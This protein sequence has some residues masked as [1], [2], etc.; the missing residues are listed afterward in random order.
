MTTPH[1]AA[2]LSQP[3]AETSSRVISDL[4]ELAAL[5]STP[6]GAQRVAWAPVWRT[7][8]EWLRAKLAPLNLQLSTDP[9]GNLWATLP[10]TSD[11]TVIVG[12]H[13]NSVP[14]GGWLACALGCVSRP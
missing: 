13:A 9:A 6:D 7:A 5:T 10:G 3:S 1:P 2:H 4:R 8:R 14:N 12:S 11:K